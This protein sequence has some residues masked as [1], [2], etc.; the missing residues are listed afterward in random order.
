VDGKEL[1]VT[2]NAQRIRLSR[3][4]VTAK[5]AGHEPGAIRKHAVEVGGRLFPI[6]EAFA[7]VT[8]LDVLDFNTNQARNAFRR[9]GLRVERVA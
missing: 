8:G 7:I 5:L 3:D 2:I 1:D 9:L 6:K 4:A